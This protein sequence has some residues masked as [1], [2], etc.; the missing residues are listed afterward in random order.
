VLFAEAIRAQECV[1]YL[2]GNLETREH[3]DVWRHEK[4]EEV[5][6]E[7]EEEEE[8]NVCSTYIN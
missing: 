8:S 3:T 5:E 2:R 6:E 7:E 4:K 1:T